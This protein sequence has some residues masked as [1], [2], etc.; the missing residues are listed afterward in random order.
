MIPVL[1]IF[2]IFDTTKQHKTDLYKNSLTAPEDLDLVFHVVCSSDGSGMPREG[3][4]ASTSEHAMIQPLQRN[5]RWFHEQREQRACSA[6]L[7]FLLPCLYLHSLKVS[8]LE[9]ESQEQ[10][11]RCKMLTAELENANNLHRT[12][13][14]SLRDVLEE[15]VLR[16][17][18]FGI[19]E[20]DVEVHAT[21]SGQFLP[22]TYLPMTPRDSNNLKAKDRADSIKKER[23]SDASTTMRN[24][25]MGKR[26]RRKPTSLFFLRKRTKWGKCIYQ[27]KAE[28]P[29]Q[30]K[31]CPSSRQNERDKKPMQVAELEREASQLTDESECQTSKTKIP[32]QPTEEQCANAYA[33][34]WKTAEGR[35]E[36]SIWTTASEGRSDG[37]VESLNE[38]SS[39]ACCDMDTHSGAPDVASEPEATESSRFLQLIRLQDGS[40]E[41]GSE[42]LP[43]ELFPLLLDFLPVDEV[44]MFDVRAVSRFFASPKAWVFHLFKLMDIDSLPTLPSEKQ[45]HPVVEC[46]HKCL[47]AE[48]EEPEIVERRHRMTLEYWM[49]TSE[50]CRG[51]LLWIYNLHRWQLYQPDLVHHFIDVCLECLGCQLG[52]P[53]R[54][55]WWIAGLLHEVYPWP[56]LRLRIA[57]RM[58]DI[59]GVANEQEIVSEA[60]EG[61]CQLQPICQGIDMHFLAEFVRVI[62]S[63]E[64]LFS[65]CFFKATGMADLVLADDLAR[66]VAFRKHLSRAFSKPEML[67]EVRHELLELLAGYQ[68]PVAQN[69]F[70]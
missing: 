39:P 59:A 3:S 49:R 10:R 19:P 61:I 34:A 54:F 62:T 58:M 8:Q 67:S 41:N 66:L 26:G 18:S 46:F 56:E 14:K 70:G 64:A 7:E 50:G 57:R 17:K 55:F 28:K 42:F 12:S 15:T 24:A 45:M 48:D 52:E 37:D 22:P 31:A 53:P 40:A 30:L 11:E 69:D 21:D 60:L 2:R 63:D 6:F 27:L 13:L 44:V 38:A 32:C 51:F 68:H 16:W 20:C 4:S 65:P 36:R 47:Q 9:K 35:P 1:E 33:A 25:S 23:L 29:Q 43:T 5:W